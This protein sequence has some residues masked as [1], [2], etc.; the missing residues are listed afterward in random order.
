MPVEPEKLLYRFASRAER[1]RKIKGYSDVECREA[2]LVSAV[3]YRIPAQCRAAAG[4]RIAFLADVHFTGSASD[5]RVADAAAERIREFKPDLLLFGGDIAGYANALSRLPEFLSRFSS[6]DCPKLAVPGNWESQKLWIAPEYWRELYAA[7]GIRYMVN[8]L[9]D[10]GICT[11][12]GAEDVASAQ[13]VV[14]PHWPG[15]KRFRILL[16]HNPDTVIAL[17][18]GQMPENLA[19]LAL[20]GHTHGGQVRLPLIGA[21]K[22]ASIYGR[23]F[24][25]GL[26]QRRER[27]AKMIISSGLGSLSFP[28]RLLCRREVVCVTLE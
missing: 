23:R 6:I 27:E 17:D 12:F 21:L 3:H 4:R 7:H 18:C 14:L 24:D 10:D 13:T 16:A 9:Y 25:Y 2:A 19:D 26:Y 8:E 15:G 28:I 5:G 20:T 22:S 1:W 11:V